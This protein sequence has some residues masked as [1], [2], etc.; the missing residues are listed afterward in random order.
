MENSINPANLE[1]VVEV[2]ELSDEKEVNKL[3]ND[4]RGCVLLKKSAR[5][6]RLPLPNCDF[7]PPKT[8]KTCDN[9]PQ[10]SAHDRGYQGR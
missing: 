8:L 7:F 4:L 3:L 6:S 9:G 5:E 1:G 2:R 10:T